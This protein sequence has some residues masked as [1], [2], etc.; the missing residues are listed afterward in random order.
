MTRK[1]LRWV[2]QT[3]KANQNKKNSKLTLKWKRAKF[4]WWEGKSKT[5]KKE[6]TQ[7]DRFDFSKTKICLLTFVPI[8][9]VLRNV[10]QINKV[11]IKK[12]SNEAFSCQRSV[13]II[14]SYASRLITV[15]AAE[16]VFT[17]K[18]FSEDTIVYG[19]CQTFFINGVFCYRG[20][21]NRLYID[22]ALI[23]QDQVT[24]VIF[25]ALKETPCW[26]NRRFI[27]RNIEACWSE[28]FTAR[29]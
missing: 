1:H 7:C 29:A 11:T 10:T 28:L 22:K 24:I 23:C 18:A 14:T 4:K 8:L 21:S 27:N 15:L 2:E 3:I 9:S 25:N 5:F 16:N 19:A 26:S 12:S 13:S 20:L 17:L 6:S